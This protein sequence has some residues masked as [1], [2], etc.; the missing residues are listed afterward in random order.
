MKKLNPNV[1]NDLTR[2]NSSEKIAE[3]NNSQSLLQLS[4][5]S[6]NQPA[7]TVKRTRVPLHLQTRVTKIPNQDPDY[8]YAFGTD[9]PEYPI[10]LDNLI[11]AG[12]EFVDLT[13]KEILPDEIIQDPSWKQRVISLK[14]GEHTLY[15]MRIPKV[16]WEKDQIDRTE[17]SSKGLTSFDESKISSSIIV[18]HAEMSE[19]FIREKR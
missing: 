1:E 3:E 4:K 7:K 19:S 10:T 16:W 11:N 9:D 18:Q 12:Y 13:G 15:C 8:H 2:L 6:L 17:K 5:Q 14:D